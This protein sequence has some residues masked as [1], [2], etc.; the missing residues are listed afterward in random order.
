M[1]FKLKP[2]LIALLTSEEGVL[3]AKMDIISTSEGSLNLAHGLKLSVELKDLGDG[4]FKGIES[5]KLT[6][7]GQGEVLSIEKTASAKKVSKG[8]HNGSSWT[9]EVNR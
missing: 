2:D 3:T 4:D 7:N 1:T 9:H 5:S 6:F 8:R